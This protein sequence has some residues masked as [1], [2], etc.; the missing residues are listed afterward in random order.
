M[1]RGLE[2]MSWSNCLKTETIWPGKKKK[3]Q[4]DI[5]AVIKWPKRVQSN[6][7]DSMLLHLC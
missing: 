4:R 5:L 3:I 6:K 2:I 1:V 7:M